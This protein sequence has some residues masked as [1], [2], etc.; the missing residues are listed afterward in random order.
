M[1][2]SAAAARSAALAAE[3]VGDVAARERSEH[4]AEGHPAGHDFERDRA[5]RKLLLDAN[6]GARNDSL[7]IAEEGAGQHND[8][9]D[10]RGAGEGQM[11]RDRIR[12]CGPRA[13]ARADRR[14]APPRFSHRPI[15]PFRQTLRP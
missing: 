7:V 12:Q 3:M 11:I 1:M 10:A 5:D 6:Q 14:S 9:D 8:R 4:G 13:D 15:P 2:N